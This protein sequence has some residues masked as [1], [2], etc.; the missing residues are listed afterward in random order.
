MRS[1][2]IQAF[3]KVGAMALAVLLLAAC[4]RGANKA[5]MVQ[6]ANI[7][8]GFDVTILAEKD[9]QFDFDGAPLTT[10][11]LKSAFRYRQEEKLPM[12][13]VLLKR[14]EKQK[15]KNEH[16]I[17]LARIAYEMKIKAYWDDDG[18]ISEIR[19][20]L[21]EPESEPAAEPSKNP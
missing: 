18:Q 15:V 2:S 20:Q 10:E 12:S 1:F 7:P 17:A 13:S 8:A 14:G 16:V 5:D 6:A 11:D 4:H 3:L 21:K 19:A 9:T